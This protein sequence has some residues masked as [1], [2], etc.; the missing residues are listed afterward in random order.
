LY[1]LVKEKAGEQTY[2][3]DV[4]ER[5]QQIVLAFEERQLTTQQALEQLQTELSR[6]LKAQ[7]EQQTSDLSPDAFAVLWLLRGRRL[8]KV[9][10]IALAMNR[11]FEKHP[12]WRQSEQQDRDVR[13]AL[14]KALM[15]AEVKDVT[16]VAEWLLTVL[17]KRS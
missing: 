6:A 8:E 5:A 15:G 12:H 7:D 1:A 3:I 17:G 2:L 11:A 9:E 14:Y 13:R 4:G 16:Q 10:E